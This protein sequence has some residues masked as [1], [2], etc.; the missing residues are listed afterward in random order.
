[1]TE[2]EIR[3]DE[4]RKVYAELQT[5]S[6]EYVEKWTPL[7]GADQAKADAWNI[8]VAARRVTEQQPEKP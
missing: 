5:Y 1:M 3:A 8:L 2:A 7:V 4:R 6:V